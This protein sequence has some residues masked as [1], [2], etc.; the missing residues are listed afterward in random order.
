[1]NRTRRRHTRH[2]RRRHFCAAAA[3]ATLAMTLGI[4]ATA[5]AQ[6]QVTGGAA[7]PGRPA[8][9][10]TGTGSAAPGRPAPGAATPGRPTPGAT[11]T[12][13]A[14]AAKPPAGSTG[15][16]GATGNRPAPSASSSSAA[17]SAAA[18]AATTP[19]VVPAVQAPAT[20]SQSAYADPD[21]NKPEIESF[22]RLNLQNL[23]NDSN[24]E[25]QSKA[26]ENLNYAT[27][28]KGDSLASP[29]FLFQYGQVL[30]AAFMAKLSDKANKPTVHQRLNI[31]IVTAKFAYQA[32]AISTAVQQTTTTL[33]KDPAEPVVFWALKAAQPQVPQILSRPL[34]GN[35]TP[36]MLTAI[37]DAA[38]KNPSGPIFEEAYNALTGNTKIIFDELTELWQNRLVQYQTK[39]PQDPSADGK[40]AFKLTTKEMWSA[41]V[42]NNPKL[43]TQV[44]QMVTD[45]LS[46]AAQWADQG[47]QEDTHAQ[48]VALAR[49]CVQGLS[50]VATAEKVPS[51]TAAAATALGKLDP[52]SFPTGAKVLPVV[53]PVIQDVL[54][55][56][57][58]VKPAPQ[59]GPAGGPGANGVAGQ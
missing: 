57:K 5:G 47:G 33:L 1:M 38:F 25:A 14:T 54:A 11:G 10:A 51:L 20:P 39:V 52:R 40:P 44:I 18:G 42:A 56:F 16:P 4:F 55:N 59:V 53:D 41:V 22:V 8:P 46:A 23:F 31:A 28:P 7:A 6:G 27:Q 29:N 19:T 24:V 36:E 34:I 45:Q 58:D 12:G 32:T 26:R 2:R 21:K 48:L 49:L 30:N 17:S 13:S 35:R 50:V 9:G 43:K 37:R 3:T 15:A